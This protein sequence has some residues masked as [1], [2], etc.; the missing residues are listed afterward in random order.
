MEGKR[1]LYQRVLTRPGARLAESPDAAAEGT[2]IEPFSVYYVFERKTVGGAEWI[3][4]GAASHPPTDGWIEAGKLIDWKQTITVAFTNPAGRE[5]TLLFR[6]RDSLLDLLESET[7][8]ARS[9][10]LREAA[11]SGS[12]PEDFPVISIEPAVHIDIQE[13]FYL[14][15]ILSAEEIY[16]AS[17]FT[18]RL[19][20]VA[21]VT[22]E[23]KEKEDVLSRDEAYRALM[24]GVG[25]REE[26]L[27]DFRAAV[28]FVIDSTTSM[29]PYIE[30]TRE[31]VRS[32]SGALQRADL[33][34]KIDFGLVAYRDNTAAAP[35]LGYVSHIYAELGDKGGHD[36]F[37]Q[38]VE[39][40]K[41]ADVSSKDFIEDTYAGLLAAINDLRWDGY[42]GRYIVLITDAG[43]RAGSDPLASTGMN[44]TQARRLALDKT[45]AIYAL[46]LM[47]EEGQANH[48]TASQQYSELS[49][50]PEGGS[51]YFPV[52]AGSVERF[53]ARLDALAE[54][55]EG[56]MARAAKGQVVTK[57]PA[58]PEAAIAAAEGRD[59]LRLQDSAQRVG[60]AMQLAYLGG[61][62]GAKAPTVFQALV[63][64]RDFENPDTAALDVRVLLSKN[65]LSDLQ[66][67]LKVVLEAGKLGQI[68]PRDFFDQLKSAAAALSRDPSRVGREEARNLADLGLMGE[69]LEDL[70]YQS[71]V[72]SI[73]QDLWLSWG[74]GEQQAFLDE[75]A[76]K[77]ELY[78]SYH[79]DTDR[80]V[81]FDEGR[82]PGDAVYPVPLE[83]LP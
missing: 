59:A 62:K 78:Q 56:Q 3:E 16:L 41:P 40:V 69:Y 1:A 65:Q 45:I 2:P 55:L 57:P 38:R 11:A 30:R 31:A 79:D 63:A 77:I 25:E 14:L 75:I 13:Q 7:L 49:D 19:L 61:K 51:L 23:E 24:E 67:A 47:T 29:G 76:A 53:G 15:P 22:T 37:L 50:H 21:S 27:R 34:G 82:V 5:R 81:A 70:P 17:G 36:A 26:A 46:H 71:K 10:E 35:G 83:A 8:V 64:D 73:D 60:L 66:D 44:A 18:T 54:A 42:G 48:A 4:V 52:E 32:I 74:V 20:E 33:A 43:A 12:V 80:W 39:A 68:S 6:D 9:R 72:M 28:V 58:I